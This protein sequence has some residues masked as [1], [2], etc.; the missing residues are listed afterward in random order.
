MKENGTDLEFNA[1]HLTNPAEEPKPDTVKNV[2]EVVLKLLEN[3]TVGKILDV[4]AGEGALALKLMLR[5][6]DVEPCDL[7][8]ARFK[9]ASVPCKEVDLN[10][11]LPYLKD[12]FDF[13]ACVEVIEHLHD[14]WIAASEFSRVLKKN[15]TLIITTPNIMTVASR[16]Q[17]LLQGEFP[18]FSTK[19]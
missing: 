6:F 9:I 7:N 4:G 3:E 19:N 13:V 12:S 11:G 17:F 2:H 8:T 14:P 16:R 1:R 18:H 15:G 10:D 5:G